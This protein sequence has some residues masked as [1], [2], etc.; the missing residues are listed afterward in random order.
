MS[1]ADDFEDEMAQSVSIQAVVST[2][3]YGPVY[4]A[5]VAYACHIKEQTKNIID[6]NGTA[7]VSSLQI[8]LDGHPAIADSAKI[9]YGGASPPIMKIEKKW[10]ENGVAYATVIYT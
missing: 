9:T 2:G 3:L 8:Y 6:K 4:S 5:A 7:A 1:L 10:D